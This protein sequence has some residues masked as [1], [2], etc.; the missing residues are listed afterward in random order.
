MIKPV[1]VAVYYDEIQ[2]RPDYVPLQNN[3]GLEPVN[4]KQCRFLIGANVPLY[5]LW[6]ELGRRFNMDNLSVTH[7]LVHT[8]STGSIIIQTDDDLREALWT[9]LSVKAPLQGEE[10][11]LEIVRRRPAKAPVESPQPAS[12]PC[13]D[14][15]DDENK[16]DDTP[17]PT[18]G[19]D[20]MLD[21]LW[22]ELGRQVKMDNPSVT[23]YL[24]HI[25]SKGSTIIQTN[26]DLGIAFGTFLKVKTPRQGEEVALEIVRLQPAKVPVESPQPASSPCSVVV[27]DENKGDDTPAPTDGIKPTAKPKEEK[28]VLNQRGVE[29]FTKA[30]KTLEEMGF[31]DRVRNVDALVKTRCDLSA[32]ILILLEPH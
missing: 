4:K 14:V 17:A 3:P 10:V 11:T 31:L 18:D 26:C 1:P 7:Y 28:L 19:I 8:T 30:L 12:S 29:T 23:Q 24:V 9:F 15:V 20:V 6:P 22:H 25:T 32:A 27:D 21:H 16:G 13:S 5:Q 2:N